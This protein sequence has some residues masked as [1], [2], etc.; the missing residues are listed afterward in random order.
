MR[1]SVEHHLP[2]EWREAERERDGR[3]L[4][5]GEAEEMY[6]LAP[7]PTLRASVS[8]ATLEIPGGT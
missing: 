6:L 3:G 2:D 5:A 7:T 1:C 8:D 4:Q